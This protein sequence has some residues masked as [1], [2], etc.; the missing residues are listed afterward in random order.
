[1]SQTTLSNKV[2]KIRKDRQCS[3]CLRLFFIGSKMNYWTGIFDG[4][5]SA[6]YSCL[7]CVEIMNAHQEEDGYCEGYTLEC[8]DKGET[9]EQY[10]QRIKSNN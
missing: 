6:S 10:V 9:P 8:P 4:D 7:T 3:M 2:V 1:M 5:F